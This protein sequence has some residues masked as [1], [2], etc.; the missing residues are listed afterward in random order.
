[1]AQSLAHMW[2]VSHKCSVRPV[3]IS[4]P[5]AL[6]AWSGWTIVRAD[7]G[8]ERACC[9]SSVCLRLTRDEGLQAQARTHEGPPDKQ[10]VHSRPI[11]RLIAGVLLLFQG[12][13]ARAGWWASP[14]WAAL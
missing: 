10:A 8:V 3:C 2:H 13:G 6:L 7:T 5:A 9:V 14:F 1:M 12:T 11:I 4:I